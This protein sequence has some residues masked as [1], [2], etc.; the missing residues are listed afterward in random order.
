VDAGEKVAE[1]ELV[2][3]GMRSIEVPVAEKHL[4][5]VL[6]HPE[7]HAVR[8]AF[9]DQ[10]GIVG[11]PT[12]NVAILPAGHTAPEENPNGRACTSA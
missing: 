8:K 2:P 12:G 9:S 1:P 10:G 4:R 5:L 11:E 6:R 3:R 7:L